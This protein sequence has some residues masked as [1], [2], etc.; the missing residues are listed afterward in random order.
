MSAICFPAVWFRLHFRTQITT[1]VLIMIHLFISAVHPMLL[2]WVGMEVYS[3]LSESYF[4]RFN[5]AICVHWFMEAYC[6]EFD[7]GCQQ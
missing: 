7:D 2:P 4:L 3:G 5:H 1:V 6:D